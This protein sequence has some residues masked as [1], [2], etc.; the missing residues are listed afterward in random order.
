MRRQGPRAWRTGSLVAAALCLAA[1]AAQ[2]APAPSDTL[3][4]DFPPAAQP[5]P[6]PAD[7]TV[8]EAMIPMRDGVKLYTLIVMRQGLTGAPILL[9]RTPYGAD[10]QLASRSG[11][12]D[13]QVGAFYAPYAD[14]GYILV[15][16]D[17]RGKNRSEGT[18]VTNRPLS[19]PLNRTGLD[20]AT[21]TYDTL[22]WLVKNL[23]ETNG[24]VGVVGGSY[25]GFTALMA[26]LSDHPALKA[27]VAINPMVDVWKGD[28]WFHNGA[29]RPITLNVLPIVM[30]G[31][32]PGRPA[33]APGV[34]LYGEMLRLG[35]TGD[36]L[37]RYGLDAYPLVR[38]FVSHPAYDD[39]WRGQALDKLL[40]A[41]PIKVPLLLV[42]GQYDEQD[43]YGAPA[44][45]RALHPLDRDHRVSLL[46][47][48]WNHM[49]VEGDGTGFGPVRWG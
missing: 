23:P 18:Y 30:S 5:R 22:D 46:L 3:A 37:R 1:F 45:F 9:E 33:T 4:S 29:F 7:F 24:R 48:P 25:D 34:D 49:G 11:R 15:W 38:R 10:A 28:D 16:Q 2:A 6:L 14:D 26:T 8:R 27:A 21:D 47:G 40:A 12:L 41:R 36:F 17:V 42:A 39:L 19:G 35:S 13:Q 31:K 44:V 20:H 43:G 32:T